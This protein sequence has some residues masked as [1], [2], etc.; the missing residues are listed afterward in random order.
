MALAYSHDDF[1]RALHISNMAGWDTDCNVGNVGCIMGLV[2]GLAGIHGAP[3]DWFSDV[4]DHVLASLILGS[5]CVLDIPTAA[6]KVSNLGRAVNGL[7]ER[8]AFKGGSKYHFCF[9][10]STHCWEFERTPGQAAVREMYN[11]TYGA[12]R[13]QAHKTRAL[14]IVLN[15]LSQ[16]N[17]G[18]AYRKTFFTGDDMTRS[19]YDIGTSPIIYPGQT[20]SATVHLSVGDGVSARLFVR[21]YAT[22][23]VLCGEPVPLA[24]GQ[25]AALEHTISCPNPVLLDRLGVL[26]S[27]EAECTAVAY[28]DRVDWSGS[29]HF[30]LDLTGPNAMAGWGYLRGRWFPRGGA[31]NAS[32][33]GK[34]A[35]AYTGLLEW[36]DYR[37]ET[38]L[39]PHCGER[40]RLLFR[41]GGAQ[42]SYAFSLAP[43]G[44][45]AFEK[46]WQGYA[47]VAS[48]PLNWELQREYTL[49]VKVIGDTMVGSVDGKRLLEWQDTDQPWTHGCV[50]LGVK[51]GRTR[52]GSLSLRPA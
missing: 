40:H 23:Q 10:G 20:L 31:L 34:D 51:N 41:V 27:A 50:G 1:S 7:Q 18:V 37:C 42:R 30:D 47:E 28:L 38:R 49:G 5:E 52:F 3:T 11:S 9:P 17:L 32:H 22:Q 14:K 48:A 45:V 8:R 16:E 39:T 33:Y 13:T 2:A 6:L 35:E 15:R 24:A 21:D 12:T 36:Q 26:F 44:R 43:N 4:N 19:G 46:N 25:E 29:P